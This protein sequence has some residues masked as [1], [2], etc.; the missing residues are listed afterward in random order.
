MAESKADCEGEVELFWLI[1]E[2]ER[3]LLKEN[4]KL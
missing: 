4:M 3:D 1:A 2:A